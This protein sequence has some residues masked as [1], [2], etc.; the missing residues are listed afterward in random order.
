MAS[1]D[2]IRTLTIRA[3]TEG[4]DQAASSMAKLADSQGKVVDASVKLEKSTLSIDAAY[5]KTDRTINQAARAQAQIAEAYKN[6]NAARDA[7]R[8]SQDTANAQMQQ[9]IRHFNG[10]TAAAKQ[11]SQALQELSNVSQGLAGNLGAV[12]GIMARLG[13]AGLAIGAALGAMT[14]AFGAAAVAALDLADKAGKL[15]DLS[16]TIGVTVV[17][18]QALELAGAQVGLS[19]DQVSG[20]LEKFGATLGSLRDSS[21]GTIEVFERLGEG[22]AQQVANATS[23][24][25]AFDLVANKLNSVDVV[26]RRLA[27]KEIFGKG[28][29]GF[30]RLAA[31][32]Q[33][34]GG[35][36][37]DLVSK[38]NPLD[39]ITRKQAESWDRLGDSINENMKLA[40]QN[41]QTTF[42]GPTLAIL[43]EFSEELLKISRVAKEVGAPLAEAF[44][45]VVLDAI[46]SVREEVEKF[47]ASLEGLSNAQKLAKIGDALI[48]PRLV[49]VIG[50]II[51]LFKDLIAVIQAAGAALSAF[52]SAPF[53]LGNISQVFT[54]MNTA[55]SN[56]QA[57][58][59]RLGTSLTTTG[60]R[61][62]QAMAPATDAVQDFGKAIDDAVKIPEIKV[63]PEPIQRFGAKT[64]EAAD[65]TKKLGKAIKEDV[66]PAIKELG[67]IAGQLGGAL[68]TAFLNGDSAAKALNNTLKSISASAASSAINNLIKGD[69]AGA[70]VSGGISLVSGI[71]SFLFGDDEDEKAQ[72]EA[73]K[74]A[75][76]AA[77]AA[78]AALQQARDAFAGLS[79]E[80]Q[81]FTNKANGTTIGELT[82]ALADFSDQS[83]KL[84]EAA[85]AAQNE[86]ALEAIRQTAA[87]GMNRFLRQ[88]LNDVDDLISEFG[89]EGIMQ[90]A[91]Q[92]VRDL[93]S[94][95]S[96]LQD[97]IDEFARRTGADVEILRQTLQT[98][99]IK[100]L[101][102]ML[103][104]QTPISETVSEMQRLKGIAS[105]LDDALVALGMSAEDAAIMVE[106]RLA[107]ALARL[108][109]SFL[110]PIIREINSF[111][112]GDWINQATDLLARV[113]QLTADATAL[114]LD[115]TLIQ[116]FFVLSARDIIN[117]NQLVGDSFNR[118]VAM[119]GLADAGLK[120][121]SAAVED[122]T[123]VIV[124]SAQ[125]IANAIASNE[126]RLFL[127]LHRSE[128]LADQLARFD[129]AAQREREA[130]IRAG[131]QALASLERALAQERLNIINDF[132]Q[133]QLQAQQEAAQRAAEEAARVRQE[134]IDA[135]K[136][137]A[138]ER[139][140]VLQEAKD[141]IQGQ[142]R[143]INDWINQFL[144]S[145]QSPLP[146]SQQ[147]AT[148]RA[149]FASE[150]ALAASGNRDALS[151]ITSSA[152]Q[153]VDSVR[154][155]FGSSTAGQTII[156]QLL[157]SLRTLP[158]QLS[159]EEFIVKGLS[160]PINNIPPA[161][162]PPITGA[163]GNQTTILQA[164]L[165]NLRT[166]VQ[167][168]DAQATAIALLP[169]FEDLDTTMD[170]ALSFQELLQGLGTSFS[171][172]TLRQIFTELDGNGNGLLEKSELIKAASQ[173]T[174][175]N[176]DD[177]SDLLQLTAQRIADGTAETV[178]WLK[179]VWDKQVVTIQTLQTSNGYLAQIAAWAPGSNHAMG[180]W[181]R[182]GT[183]GR[184]SV[185]ARLMPGEFVVREAIA[186]RNPWLDRFNATG[187]L[188][189]MEMSAPANDNSVVRAIGQLERTLLRGIKALIDTELEAAGI[190]AAP[191]RESNKITRT[192]RGEKKVA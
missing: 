155:Y 180:G 188:P 85:I 178:L 128:S 148:A 96:S 116:T 72:A 35:S 183:P 143:R 164:L 61:A 163:I 123:A 97:S 67:Q 187:Y 118:L 153:V 170:Q 105:E 100:A 21:K 2:V 8:I 156:Q 13:P 43:N 88:F 6:I 57:S 102:D 147:M 125:E 93:M 34:A 19:A 20:G 76:E 191:L 80:I 51:Q 11:H 49:Q 106:N 32:V 94:Q 59:G 69:F 130:E 91:R 46:R 109:E 168:G 138:E 181:I 77:K 31:E 89:T 190:V 149:N 162:T 25:D 37:D 50:D 24:G 81:E 12:G 129:L 192:R 68:V 158:S 171:T 70:A 1:L 33:K 17:Q 41:I 66:N 55:V 53:S 176:T 47:T 131:G 132:N 82:Q 36:I 99:A 185:N 166:A 174:R 27:E 161:V 177:T 83:V 92:S 139:A 152:Q 98:N 172:G 29:A 136:R 135:A 101:L 144:S 23:V 117:Q 74:Q 87:A 84:Q 54:D 137:A 95:Y 15:V 151:N 42:A 18:L 142:V 9:A 150:Y 159:P 179:Q 107:A 7:G 71:A 111:V 108:S 78:A 145:E 114:G 115:T 86:T 120:Q 63:D 169:L 141:F 110:D 26:T 75:A 184:D 62:E 127:A 44:G 73:A 60:T 58:L 165:Q 160:E 14:L 45:T 3:K 154:R 140:R 186:S 64:L 90:D 119:L 39:V 112:G 134:Q 79:R 146:P 16:D 133:Q 173:A 56:A 5:A 167:T 65:S 124:R 4:V 157:T 10:A 52:L 126:D 28:G 104:D 38:M 189:S 103:G 30:G 175:D 122:T 121:F 48:D 40:K 182:G 113:R 22:F